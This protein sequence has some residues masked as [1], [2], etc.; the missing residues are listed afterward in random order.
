MTSNCW[1][2]A[3]TRSLLGLMFLL[4]ALM[5]GLAPALAK[6]NKDNQDNADAVLYEVTEDMYLV[7]IEP[8]KPVRYVTNPEQATHR[9]AVAQ[10]S[11][12]AKLGTPL[13]PDWVLW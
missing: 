13:C 11:G 10:L 9:M 1:K 12:F 3:V 7:V 8:G 2:S 6:D 5:F 4:F